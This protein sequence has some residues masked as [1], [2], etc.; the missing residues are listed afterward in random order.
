M[1]P[2][3]IIVDERE[4]IDHKFLNRQILIGV[5][6]LVF[7]ILFELTEGA[8]LDTLTLG[9]IELVP[10]P[11][12]I[13]SFGVVKLVEMV[14]IKLDPESKKWGYI[15]ALIP[16]IKDFINPVVIDGLIRIFKNWKLARASV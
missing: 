7:G 3:Q 12:L 1:E 16:V 11:D 9:L 10:G 15:C 8:I 2:T 5:A 13:S 14:G 4:Q 6:E